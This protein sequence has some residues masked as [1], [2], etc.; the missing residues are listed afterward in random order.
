MRFALRVLPAAAL[1]VASMG[2]AARAQTPAPTPEPAP[3]PVAAPVTQDAPPPR[4][5]PAPAGAQLP[6]MRIVEPP[7]VSIAKLPAQN[8]YGSTA[9]IPAALP[10]KLPLIDSTVSVG[11][12]ISMHVDPTGKVLMAKRERDPIPSLAAETLKS[13]QRWTFSPGRKGGQP[14]DTWGA[15]RLDLSV[16]INAPKIVQVSF[17]P[18]SGTAPLPAPFSWPPETEWLESRRPAPVTDGSVSIV[19]VDTAPI[20]QKTP[21]SADSFKGPF[22]VKFWVKVGKTGRIEKAIPIQTSDPVLLSYFRTAMSTW[23]MRPA[24]SQGAP[25]DS[26]NELLLSGQVSFDDEIKQIVALRRAL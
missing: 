18:V 16:E 26:W 2:V 17:L 10:A 15:Y 24:R 6:A 7:A 21:W 4:A 8:P 25:V 1:L 9:D 13:F 23:V 11:F 20:P 22:T 14:V 12:F 5:A 19:E 3:P